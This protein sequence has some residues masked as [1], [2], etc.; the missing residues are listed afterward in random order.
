VKLF[1]PALHSHALHKRA[2]LYITAAAVLEAGNGMQ[3]FSTNTNKRYLGITIQYSEGCF[4]FT[5]QKNLS[6]VCDNIMFIL[7]TCLSCR[8]SSDGIMGADEH[9]LESYKQ[10]R[11]R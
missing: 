6:K 8:G 2:T 9:V 4:Q 7:F 5:Y 10:Q 11:Y 3:I 1:T